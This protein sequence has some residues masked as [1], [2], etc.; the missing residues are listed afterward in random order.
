M[1][2]GAAFRFGGPDHEIEGFSLLIHL[3]DCL[4]CH[5]HCDEFAECRHGDAVFREHLAFRDDLDFRSFDLLLHIQV[6]YAFDSAYQ[7]LDLVSE[8]EHPVQI[9]SEQLDGDSGLC[10]AEHGI[11]PVADRLAYLD[12][13]PG[14]G[15]KL[16]ADF[17]QQFGMGAVFQFERRF[18][19][20]YVH[21][22][23]MFVQLGTSG[24]AGHSLYLRY[25]KQEFFCLASYLVG[26]FE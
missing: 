25:G 13:G 3:R 1:F 24:L 14:D 22:E 5:V 10:A 18:D 8:P 4:S 15:R 12:V 7:V 23:C 17:R 2:Y 16:F 9:V 21:S 20:G 26:F 11:D 6:G 19:L